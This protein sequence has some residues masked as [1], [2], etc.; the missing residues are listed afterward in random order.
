M[1]LYLDT[2]ALLYRAYHAVPGLQTKDG[3]PTGALFGLFNTL[4]RAIE[5]MEPQHVVACFD[6]PEPT[7]REELHA[8]YKANREIP[9]DDMIVQINLA[10]E[11][12]HTFGVHVV[13]RAGYE[14]DDLLGTLAVADVGRDETVVVIT[15]DGD[16]LQLTVHPGIEVC[17]LQG[18][19]GFVLYNRQKVEEKNGYPVQYITDHKGLAGDSSD[20]IAGVSGI[21]KVF[22]NRLITAFGDLDSIYQALDAGDLEKQGFSK[23]I[24]SLLE[25]GRDSAFRSRDLATIDTDVPVS[26]SHIGS[27]VWKDYIDSA[28]ARSILVRYEFTSLLSRFDRLVGSSGDGEQHAVA[29]EN[30]KKS[31]DDS[32]DAVV[33]H[34]MQEAIVA[35]WVLDA[36]QTNASF[37]DVCSYTSTRVAADALC[38]IE[39]ELKKCNLLSVWKQIEQPLIPVVDRIEQTGICFDVSGAKQ[40]SN[41]YAKKIDTLV[42]KM[43]ELAG[44]AFNVSSPKQLGVVLYDTLGL[45]P[46]K[47]G[48]TVS[49]HRTTKESV[50][51]QM[52]DDHPIVPLVLEYRHHEKIRSTYVDAL[53]DF[54][55]ED[56]RIHTTLLQNGT[57]TGRFSSRDPNLQNIPSGGVAGTALRDLFVASDGWVMLSADY[58]QV[59][60]RVVAILSQDKTLIDMFDRGVD[61]HRAVAARIFSVSEDA[62]SDEQR[63]H[64]KTI[65]FGVLYGMGAQS[66][67]R[68]L[69]VSLTDADSFLSG[70]KKLFPSLFDYL[71]SIKKEA[72]SSGFVTTAFG[73]VRPVPGIS[74]PLP[75]VRAHAERS[76]VNTV[77]QGTAADVI[78][79]AMVSIDAMISKEGVADDV[80]M[81]LQIHDELLFEVRS[82][83]ADSVIERI[84]SI[85]ESVYPEN[86]RPIPLLVNVARGQSWGSL[87]RI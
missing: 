23:R 77:I 42:R 40:L 80:R 46:K 9:E 20:N 81:L 25:R 69:G 54:V 85:M 56:G 83:V 8:E 36:N 6:H 79:I 3:V 21:G 63:N 28:G 11:M 10:R 62:V 64:A 78:K 32:V 13:D 59:E 50:L 61:V 48:K 37:S 49:G 87:S 51:L 74:S 73:R 35:L 18:M 58:S 67:S 15:C 44:G 84:I 33:T 57:A 16:L 30:E 75:Y 71:N 31:G 7:L 34:A 22:A 19:S 47:V 45:K 14:A 82:G 72:R 39:K 60:L 27:A 76:A 12:L 29:G 55:G 26:G 86:K 2:L 38:Y 1:I 53:S 4:F 52:Q 65:N 17:L 41:Q 70:Y 43:Y 24:A 5:E 66:L 68:S